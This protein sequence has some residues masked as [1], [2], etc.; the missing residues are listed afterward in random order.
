MWCASDDINYGR[1]VCDG[2]NAKLNINMEGEDGF[3]V[4]YP[5]KELVQLMEDSNNGHFIHAGH[6]EGTGDSIYLWRMAN[7]CFTPWNKSHWLLIATTKSLK[8]GS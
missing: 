4:K 2:W 6:L 3:H 1:L 8:Q 5:T 7:M